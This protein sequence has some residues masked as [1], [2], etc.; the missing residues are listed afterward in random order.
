MPI[1][2]RC[3]RCSLH[4]FSYENVV[5]HMI[6]EHGAKYA[7]ARYEVTE[8]PSG[9]PVPSPTL[10][11]LEAL[12]ALIERAEREVADGQTVLNH[13]RKAREIVALTKTGVA[14]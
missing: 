10:A 4:N 12:D 5:Q 6:H 13:L 2:Y 7:Q 3:G 1:Q 11:A 9:R 8:A 14:R